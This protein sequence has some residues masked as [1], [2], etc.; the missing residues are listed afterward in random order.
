M[1]PPCAVASRACARAPE[2]PR[3][4]RG[5]K[6]EGLGRLPHQLVWANSPTAIRQ[7]GQRAAIIMAGNIDGDQRS[8]PCLS[9]ACGWE[10]RIQLVSNVVD[11]RLTSSPGGPIRREASYQGAEM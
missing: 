9:L 10:A 3:R 8:F 4:R 7:T 6:L 1:S 5:L 11:S 2:R